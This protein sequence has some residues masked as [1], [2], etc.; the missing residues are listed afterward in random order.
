[1]NFILVPLDICFLIIILIFALS[2][3][4]KGL[5]KE[6]FSKVSFIGGLVLAII[7]TPRLDIYVSDSIKN[8]ALHCHLVRAGCFDCTAV[9]RCIRHL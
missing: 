8:P 1:M 7:F 6:L 4:A 9:A 3:L 2:A 5:I